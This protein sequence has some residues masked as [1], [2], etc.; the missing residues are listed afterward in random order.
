MQQLHQLEEK[1][2]KLRIFQNKIAAYFDTRL[3]AYD[4]L[5]TFFHH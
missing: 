5:R 4:M 1:K 2:L 3:A